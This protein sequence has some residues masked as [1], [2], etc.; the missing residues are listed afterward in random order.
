M[1]LNLQPPTRVI[2]SGSATLGRK[3]SSGIPKWSASPGKEGKEPTEP[4][5][6]PGPVTGMS[7]AMTRSTLSRQCVFSNS[8]S[9]RS[10]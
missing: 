9:Y 10:S 4:N 8:E 7:D 1:Y 2:T 3:P 6:T 5:G